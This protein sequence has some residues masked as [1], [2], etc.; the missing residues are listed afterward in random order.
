[1]SC[2]GLVV[3]ILV[4][5]CAHTATFVSTYHLI[6]ML[7]LIPAHMQWHMC[8]YMWWYED[9]HVYAQQHAPLMHVSAQHHAHLLLDTAPYNGHLTVIEALWYTPPQTIQEKKWAQYWRH[10]WWHMWWYEDAQ[11][12]PQFVDEMA[13][14][15]AMPLFPCNDPHC[16]S[17]CFS[18]FCVA[19]LMCRCSRCR[20][21]AWPRAS[22]TGRLLLRLCSGYTTALFWLYEGLIRPH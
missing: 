16:L 20:R 13:H 22:P 12:W 21:R 4:H 2:V 9:E 8:W 18:F 1:M 3:E 11:Y 5:M 10:M 6:C 14:L 19:G 7:V 15:D 17:F